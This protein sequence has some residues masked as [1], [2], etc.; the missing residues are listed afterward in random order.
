ML[1]ISKIL[2]A[3]IDPEAT[4]IVINTMTREVKGRYK[5]KNRGKARAQAERL[6]QEYGAVI[7]TCKV[8]EE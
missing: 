1:K 6:N 4:Y 2:K 3:S 5:Y 7:Y 8:V